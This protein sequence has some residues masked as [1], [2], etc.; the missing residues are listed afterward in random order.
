MKD[1]WLY[2]DQLFDTFTDQKSYYGGR[3]ENSSKM[4]GES[5]DKK[6][7]LSVHDLHLKTYTCVL[8]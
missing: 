1:I 8:D 6:L 5:R 2:F 4:L 7:G 3:S